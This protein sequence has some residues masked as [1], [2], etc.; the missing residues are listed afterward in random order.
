[1]A[2]T[3]LKAGC[4]TSRSFLPAEREWASASKASAAWALCS[5]VSV[6]WVPIQVKATRAA[7]MVARSLW[8]GVGSGVALLAASVVAGRESMRSR[9]VV[10]VPPGV[11]GANGH[12][13]IARFGV[14]SGLVVVAAAQL[15]EGSPL[16]RLAAGLRGPGAGAGVK[17]S[18]VGRQ[19]AAGGPVPKPLDRL[20]GRH[21]HRDDVPG[22][23]DQRDVEQGRQPAARLDLG[24][25][26]V[27][28]LGRRPVRVEAVIL[29]VHPPDRPLLPGP[30][31][32]QEERGV[33]SAPI[34]RTPGGVSRYHWPC[35][36]RTSRSSC[37]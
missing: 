28:V 11:M 33:E 27:A 26:P 4:L 2:V 23:V 6:F 7:A 22:G 29:P 14:G 35:R 20:A 25:R 19:A 32:V 5:A 36:R 8:A 1:M 9:S 24:T 3:A 18:T 16:L 15:A 31:Q 17:P 34:A 13:A 30:R 21:R 12:E 10:I 37:R